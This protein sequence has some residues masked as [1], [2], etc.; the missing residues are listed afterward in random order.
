M[1]FFAILASESQPS[2][3]CLGANDGW[4]DDVRRG[5]DAFCA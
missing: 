3:R 5:G 4:H 2:T 1:I